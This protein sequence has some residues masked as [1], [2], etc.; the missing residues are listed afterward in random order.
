[1]HLY[2]LVNFVFHLKICRRRLEN[3]RGNKK[4]GSS[5]S[6]FIGVS[7]AEFVERMDE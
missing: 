1:V 5:N 6:G 7:A 4:K 2:T 3:E